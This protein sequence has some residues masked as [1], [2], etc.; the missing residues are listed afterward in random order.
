MCKHRICHSDS[1]ATLSCKFT[2]NYQMMV[3][4]YGHFYA[5]IRHVKK[6]LY[7]VIQPFR[8]KLNTTKIPALTSKVLTL[9]L[10]YFLNHIQSLISKNPNLPSTNHQHSFKAS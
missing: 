3:I 2:K 9:T 1:F 10:S 7:I 4:S 8:A 5:L 6:H